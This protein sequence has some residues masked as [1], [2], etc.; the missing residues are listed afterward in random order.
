M[1][2]AR[3]KQVYTS[4]LNETAVTEITFDEATEKFDLRPIRHTGVS[5]GPAN[6]LI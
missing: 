2:P 3:P 1:R 4:S 6:G 5:R